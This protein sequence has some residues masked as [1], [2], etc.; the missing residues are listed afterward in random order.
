MAFITALTL[1]TGY[2]SLFFIGVF[3]FYII[4]NNVERKNTKEIQVYIIILIEAV[5]LSQTFYSRYIVGFFSG[6]ARET[7]QTLF[8]NGI[9]DNMLSSI[10]CIITLIND[11]FFTIPVIILLATLIVYLLLSKQKIVFDKL[12]L[13][14]RHCV[15]I[16]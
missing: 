15:K 11:H 5:L 6:R 12:I 3:G 8:Q 9:F 10:I 2:Y 1:L 4:Y 7:A 14:L 16:T 13:L